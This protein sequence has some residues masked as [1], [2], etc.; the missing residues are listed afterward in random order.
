MAAHMRQKQ[1]LGLT[2]GSLAFKIIKVDMVIVVNID[3]NRDPANGMDGARLRRIFAVFLTL[4][5]LNMLRKALG[6]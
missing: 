3:Q 6:Y 4:V 5:A 2:A 1:K